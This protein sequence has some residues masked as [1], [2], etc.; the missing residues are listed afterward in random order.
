MQ[1]FH[2]HLSPYST[3]DNPNSPSTSP[4]AACSSGDRP[5]ALAIAAVTNAETEGSH[6]W[7]RTVYIGV[8]LGDFCIDCCDHI[9]FNNIRHRDVC[10]NNSEI[11][12]RVAEPKL[13]ELL[14]SEIFIPKFFE[15]AIKETEKIDKKMNPSQSRPS[16]RKSKIFDYASKSIG[17]IREGAGGV[18]NPTIHPKLS[19]ARD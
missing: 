13:C 19:T 17:R 9:S 6:V 15:R 16:H 10:D 8:D 1:Y 4:N 2:V 5:R 3:V 12:R 18:A 7:L 14:F 11:N